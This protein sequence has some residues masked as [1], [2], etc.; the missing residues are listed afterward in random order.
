MPPWVSPNVTQKSL[1]CAA[2]ASSPG[3]LELVGGAGGGQ[4]LLCPPPRPV[5]APARCQAPLGSSGPA[6]RPS[7]RLFSSSELWAREWAPQE[8]VVWLAGPSHLPGSPWPPLG[9][10]PCSGG[11]GHASSVQFPRPGSHGHCCAA[12]VTDPS[13]WTIPRSLAAVSPTGS[14]EW[15]RDPAQ[16]SHACP[17]ATRGEA[18]WPR[19]V[20]RAPG[21]FVPVCSPAL[22]SARL[23]GLLPCTRLGA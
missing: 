14:S 15:L 20:S 23:L 17:S 21:A 3:P 11:D 8:T 16:G 18:S 10:S 2:H 12:P 13:P 6:Q 9:L 22:L 4:A 19:A 7:L 5:F 1:S